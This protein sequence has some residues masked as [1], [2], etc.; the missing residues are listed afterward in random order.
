[1][2]FILRRRCAAMRF[3]RRIS[4]LRHVFHCFLCSDSVLPLCPYSVPTTQF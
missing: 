3:R 2:L 1:M 4:L